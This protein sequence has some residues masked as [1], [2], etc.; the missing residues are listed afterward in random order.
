MTDQSDEIRRL[1]FQLKRANATMGKQGSTIHQLR[2]ELA[3]VRELHSKIQRGDLRRLELHLEAA[4]QQLRNT[5]DTIAQLRAER[6]AMQS[7]PAHA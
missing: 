3:E 2:A 6:A 7:E 5:H 4:E 1:K